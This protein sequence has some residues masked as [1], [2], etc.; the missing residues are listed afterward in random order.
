[1]G[2]HLLHL[3]HRAAVGVV[4]LYGTTFWGVLI[5][6]VL[7]SALVEIHKTLGAWKSL[8]AGQRSSLWRYVVSSVWRAK[9][10]VIGLNI[11]AWGI[12]YAVILV[13]LIYQDHMALVAQA[14]TA[15]ATLA[16]KNSSAPPAVTS[17][18]TKKSVAPITKPQ[19]LPFQARPAQPRTQIPQTPYERMLAINK[20]LSQSDRNRLSDALYEFSR[21]LEEGRT[22][23]Y[24]A[25]VVIGAIQN[26][27]AGIAK[28]YQSRITTLRE[29]AVLSKQYA[30]DFMAL[31]YKWDYY[32]Q[33]AEYVFGDNPDNLGP[34]SIT[35]A[36]EGLANQLERWGAVQNKN[37]QNVLYLLQPAEN[38]F[39]QYL[40]TF[41][42]W[43]LDSKNRMD[44]VRKSLNSAV[45]LR[46]LV[47]APDVRAFI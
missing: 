16:A 25:Y 42:K 46:P 44:E 37:D 34:N 47:T 23:S 40:G 35:N 31:R 5:L 29:I 4:S 11:A 6:T 3:L 24:K 30:K 9:K 1:M 10:V 26:E 12:A 13:Q 22:I 36:V 15:Q 19:P 41:S 45:E 21:S 17:P 33:Q 7:V 2:E 14:Q 27:H 28:D 39:N 38:E 18:P 20:N 32:H 43:Y 8:P